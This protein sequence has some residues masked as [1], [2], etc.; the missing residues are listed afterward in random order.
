MRTVPSLPPPISIPEEGPEVKALGS[1]RAA[2][3]VTE[4]AKPPRV[5]NRY[6]R[7]ASAEESGGEHQR[8]GE[9]RRKLCRRIDKDASPLMDTRA[10]R[11]RRHR[12]RRQE[13]IK[14]NVEEKA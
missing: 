13:D 14:T 12:N 4:P 9:D 11:D 6:S 7:G 5:V 3:R 8:S 1:I 2:R 10:D